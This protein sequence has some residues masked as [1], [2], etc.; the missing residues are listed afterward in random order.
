MAYESTADIVGYGGAAGG[1][2]GL[3]LDTPIPTP[4]GW[5][6]M[7]HIVPGD[8]LFDE[9]GN[10]CRV[11]A[12][13]E[14]NLRPCY[15]LTFDDGSTIVADDVHRWVTFNAK[16]LAAL[17][18]RDPDW[19]AQ[20]RAQRPSRATG[21]KS[22]KFA[23]SLA[24]RNAARAAATAKLPLP[25][26]TMRDTLELFNTLR[27]STGRTNHAIKV[28]G[29]L[30]MPDA[31]LP[32]PAY[33]LGAWLG[34]GSS[35][36][37]QITGIDP[38][39]WTN[40]EADGFSVR[41]YD[42]SNQAH[43]VLGL[44]ARLRDA[45]VL[46]NKHIP[47]RYL[48]ASFEQRL[49]LLQG[50]MDTDGHAATDG[51]CE[52]DGVNDRLVWDV[53]E[54]VL[55]LGIKATLQVGEAKLQGRYISPKYRVKF[56][57]DLPVFRIARKLQRLG[58]KTARRV[59]KFRYLVSCE[60][61]SP[62]PTR[63][64][65]VDSATRQYLAGV[66]FIP[67]H[68]TD[69][70]CG[71][72]VTKHK[73]VLVIRYEKAQTEGIIQRLSEI[74]GN[75]DG[76]NS[77]KGIWKTSVGTAPLIE[78]GGLDNPG[79]ERRWQGR[80][81]D[82]KCFDEV[83]EQREDQVRFIMGWTR[84]SDP[85]LHPQV[86]MTFNPP[87]TTEGRWV[88]KFFAP[89]LDKKHPNP[90]KPGELRWFTTIGDDHDYEVPDGRPFVLLDDGTFLYEFDED[91][92]P[93]ERIIRPK[94]RTFIP[95]R[96]TDNKFYMASGYVSQLQSLPEPLRSQM[97][98][99]DFQAGIED[100][101]WQVI[102][103]TWVEA[104]MARWQNLQVKPRMDS[105]GVDVARGGRDNTV[106]ARR[107]GN[108]YDV[109]LTYPGSQTPNGPSVAGLVIAAT[110]DKAPQHVDVIG[111]GS[112]PYDFLVESGQQA[113]GVN[114]AEKA[115][116]TDKSGRLH[117]ANLR[118]QLWWMMRE[119]L[120]PDSNNGIALPPDDRLKADLCAP[121]WR[122]KGATIQVESREEIMDRIG[123]SPDFA[124][125]YILAQL[126]TPRLDDLP[127][128]SPQQRR[129]KEYDPYA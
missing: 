76:L 18:R 94:S 114:V 101:P 129:R 7:G 96:V 107:H 97:L 93:P 19:Q 28:C 75:T 42:W 116:R 111:V 58:I 50:L 103:T 126:D 125:A 65:S 29:A 31:A 13:S 36:N 56:M 84:T 44:Q 51:G 39:V 26:G 119:A 99:G 21:N 124:S 45:G 66:G 83:T 52:Y 11:T 82:L 74:I 120:D 48:R 53:Y 12:V 20:R 32:V 54:L 91:D 79:D 117:F 87:T 34:D 47:M 105:V 112:S 61:I 89:W 90:A 110:R 41:H 118:S 98:Y 85:S 25:T 17:T 35:R 77:Q 123:R 59:S 68:N 49:A 86:V 6:R 109:P 9:S 2:K 63:C 23:A 22:E 16:E 1:G 8:E 108:W 72:A 104:A 27:T 127:G 5:T 24:A 78:F 92:Y 70:V 46:Q 40:I 38:E 71:K 15:R 73:R 121:L 81:H 14:I 10:V 64:I 122:M 43:N 106:I 102:P 55:S 67:T 115:T 80:P 128:N 30:T 88:I 57:T 33:T 62:V 100:D 60:P 69:L 113:L 95:A 3:A 37:G 4:T